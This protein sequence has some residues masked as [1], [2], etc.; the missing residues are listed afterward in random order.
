[1][2]KLPVREVDSYGSGTASTQS[3]RPLCG[4]A[5]EFED[6]TFCD[7][8]KYTELGFRNTPD[9]PSQW[10][11]AQ[12]PAVRFLIAITGGVPESAVVS[13]R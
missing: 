6:I 4:S 9:S 5:A 11:L 2:G 12:D 3:K 7:L 8:A 10:F 1:M 13:I